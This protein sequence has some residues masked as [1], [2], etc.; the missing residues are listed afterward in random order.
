M[1]LPEERYQRSVPDLPP[2]SVG[3]RGRGYIRLFCE[4]ASKPVS[5][6]WCYLV[7][8]EGA[9]AEEYKRAADRI[10]FALVRTE[11]Q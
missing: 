4:L 10:S 5:N 11:L 2:G 1:K 8:Q 6:M 9:T 7:G 3:P